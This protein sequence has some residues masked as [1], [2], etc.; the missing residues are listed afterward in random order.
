MK[1]TFITIFPNYIE[2]LVSHSI[3]KRSIEKGLVEIDYVNPRD[4]A[5]DNKIDDTVYGGGDGML[6]MIEPMVKAIR[7][8]KTENSKVYL[9]GPRGPRFNQDRAK[10]LS[11][12][13]HLILISGHYEGVDS[14]IKHYIDGEISI[15]DF[16]LTGGELP[17][18]MVADAIIR[19]IPGVIKE[20]SHQ[21]ESFEDNLLEH[22]HFTKP[23][24]FEG[25]KVPEVLLG[26]N[27]QEIE[28]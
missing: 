18:M 13:E 9:M 8:V 27:H 26:G 11:K 16:I 2:E 20:G 19:L 15:G 14:R 1:I 7:S 4:F 10:E 28:K 23:V 3:I 22:D 5:E 24:D 17:S 25:H 6:L 12:V 21:N